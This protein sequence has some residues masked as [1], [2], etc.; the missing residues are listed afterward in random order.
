M[1]M[2][3]FSQHFMV[4]F[5]EEG[6]GSYVKRVTLCMCVKMLKIMD[7]PLKLMLKRTIHTVLCLLKLKWNVEV[8]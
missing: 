1:H 4:R 6:G 3:K 7:G 8:T 2:N 5:G